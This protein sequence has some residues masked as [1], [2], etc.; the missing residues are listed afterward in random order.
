MY[1]EIYLRTEPEMYLSSMPERETMNNGPGTS[2]ENCADS[3][4]FSHALLCKSNKA[5]KDKH[6]DY[7]NHCT[8]K[9]GNQ[10]QENSINCCQNKKQEHY[11]EPYTETTDV[12]NDPLQQ[13]GGDKFVFV[14][15][16]SEMHCDNMFDLKEDDNDH[17]HIVHCD[18]PTREANVSAIPSCSTSLSQTHFL[19]HDERERS[20]SPFHSPKTKKKGVPIRNIET[21]S[22]SKRQRT[23]EITNYTAI[24]NTMTRQDMLAAQ[25]HVVFFCFFFTNNYKYIYIYADIYVYVYLLLF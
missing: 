3:S 23:V 25:T 16:S 10:S 22:H 1:V 19:N 17:K 11:D 8:D 15:G 21:R 20:L 13:C 5:N 2:D 14:N 7:H 12:K 18:S 9:N 4:F 24:R 6:K